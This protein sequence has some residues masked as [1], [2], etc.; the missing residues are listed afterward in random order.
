M[1]TQRN[2]DRT[3]TPPG[4]VRDPEISLQLLRWYG[5]SARDLPWRRTADPYAI[6]VSEIML[7]Q[8]RVETVRPYYTRFLERFP[9]VSALASAPEEEVLSRW[10]GL[11][12]YS[13]ARNLHRGAGVVCDRHGGQFPRNRQDALELPGIGPYTSAAILSIAYGIP[14]AVVD[15]NVARVLAR[16]F[17]IEPPWDRRARF[18]E[19]QAESL[20]L[21]DHPGDHNQAMME[22]GATVCLPREP[23]CEACPVAASCQARLDGVVDRYPSPTTR[24]ETIHLEQVLFLAQ[25]PDLGLLL[26]RG[27][28]P[29]L[30]HLW[31][32]PIVEYAGR[33]ETWEESWARWA[34][35]R[36]P[37]LIA[38]RWA[39]LGCIRHSITH[40]RIRFH[41]VGTTLAS[42]CER[43]EDLCCARP[44]EW[45]ELGHSSIL[46]KALRLR[47]GHRSSPQL[48]LPVD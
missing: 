17:R 25:H 31:I 10:S 19:E 12:Y 14:H 43:R 40:R 47:D 13:R 30:P 22:L 15:G 41:V 7:Q 26:E 1:T 48:T 3:E 18:L 5:S 38:K 42:P 29:L 36:H 20:L 34:R 27:I 21:Q 32:P 37:G 33:G 35:R 23:R 24:R 6:W 16:L 8:T 9:T 46:G 4:V 28:W 44:E 11:G 2:E 45:A 39:P